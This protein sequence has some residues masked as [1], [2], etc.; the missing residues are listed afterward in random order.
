LRQHVRK[1]YSAPG[2][3]APLKP[4]TRPRASLRF[5]DLFAGLGGFHLALARLGHQCVM[6]SEIDPEL[7]RLY[8]QNFG[9][10]PRG[11]IRDIPLQD[12]PPHDVLCAGFPCQPFSK[13][14][15]QLGTDCPDYGDLAWRIVEWLRSARPRYFLLENVPN[16]L[17]HRGGALWRHLSTD[18]R[19]SGYDLRFCILS[20]HRFGV[21]QVRERLYIVGARAGLHGFE[22]PNGSDTTTDIR[23]I[24]DERPE[25]ARALPMKVIEAIEA[26]AQFTELYPQSEPKPHFPIWAAEFGATYPFATVTPA[27]VGMR[28]LREYRGS[29]GADLSTLRGGALLAAIPPYAR[30]STARFPSWK[31]RFIQQN[32]ELYARNRR[33]IDPWKES[34]APFEPCYQKLEW[35][36]NRHAHGL[37]DTVLQLRGSGIRAKSPTSAPA[38]VALTTS[39]VPVIGWKRRFLTVRECARLQGLDTLHALP[40]SESAAFRALGNAVNLTVTSLIAER[41]L[42]PHA[43]SRRVTTPQRLY[44]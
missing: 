31:V 22:W 34:L 14:G 24:L 4:R 36:Y 1:N 39:Q 7:Q 44:A 40:T 29:F 18:L 12:I 33:W 9:V 42:A 13:A 3:I 10:T 11:D 25:R 20:P 6:A 32:R 43:S 30:A 41:L 37:W 17:R 28:T 38:L 16:L 27:A 15:M 8:S 2:A 23:S 19:Q 5:V 21:P 35:N 26:W